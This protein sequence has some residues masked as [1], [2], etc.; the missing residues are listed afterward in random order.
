M[1]S[2]KLSKVS[3][4]LMLAS[5]LGIGA[6]VLSSSPAH[7]GRVGAD[8]EVGAGSGATGQSSAPPLPDREAEGR[9]F[10]PLPPSTA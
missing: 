5:L 6:V 4:A 2:M 8:G 7:A 1:V 9:P 10:H 3:N